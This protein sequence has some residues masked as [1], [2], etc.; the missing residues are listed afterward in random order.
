M[1]RMILEQFKKL[2]EHKQEELISL[3]LKLL[4]YYQLNSSHNH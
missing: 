2:P 4:T 1:D 3:M